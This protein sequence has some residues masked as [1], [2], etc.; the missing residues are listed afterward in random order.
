MK[1][2]EGDKV[3]LDSIKKSHRT[4]TGPIGYYAEKDGLK[5]GQIYTVNCVGSNGL[6]D[7][8]DEWIELEETLFWYWHHV[9]GFSLVS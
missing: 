4:Q 6:E 3:R 8:Q 5:E 1:F 9:S 2:K 7:Q